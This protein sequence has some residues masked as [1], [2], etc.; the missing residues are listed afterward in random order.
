MYFESYRPQLIQDVM[1]FYI[2]SHDRQFTKTP[3]DNIKLAELDNERC[4]TLVYNDRQQCIAFFTL[5]FGEGIKP[6]TTNEQAVFFRSFSVDA[7]YRN[8]GIGTAVIQALPQYIHEQFPMITE[9]YLAVNDTNEQAQRLYE[10]C[11]YQYCGESELE[12][13][14]VYILKQIIT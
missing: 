13:K 11:G 6:Y 12:D 3:E 2:Q 8:L 9:I 1:D 14:R 5:H 7:R 10:R 4:P